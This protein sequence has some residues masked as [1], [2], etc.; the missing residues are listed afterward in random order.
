MNIIARLFPLKLFRFRHRQPLA[1]VALDSAAATDV[2]Q[3]HVQ[4]GFARGWSATECEALLADR[5]ICA[6]GARARNGRI[7][8]ACL[9]RQAGD[10]AEILVVLVAPS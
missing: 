1:Q 8:A 10:E 3:L 6:D 7:A 2:A 5:N 9:S 4:G